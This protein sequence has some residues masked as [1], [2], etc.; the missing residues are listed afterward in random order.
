M[1]ASPSLVYRILFKPEVSQAIIKQFV[2][3]FFC[4]TN[5]HSLSYPTFQVYSEKKKQKTNFFFSNKINKEE[6]QK[7]RHK[8]GLRF[9]E[10]GGWERRYRCGVDLIAIR[11]RIRISSRIYRVEGTRV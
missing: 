5:A 3:K 6:K 4:R 9:A 8:V 1:I 2:S 7:Y 11:I 10:S